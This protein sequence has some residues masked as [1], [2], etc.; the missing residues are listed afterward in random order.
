MPLVA[1]TDS[2]WWAYLFLTLL[3]V[4]M[5]SL[6]GAV[7]I[8]P[9]PLVL[10]QA[11]AGAALAWLVIFSGAVLYAMYSGRL[12]IDTWQGV[13][14]IAADVSASS[15]WRPRPFVATWTNRGALGR[16]GAVVTFALAILMA[17]GAAVVVTSLV[18]ALWRAISSTDPSSTGCRGVRCS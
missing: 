14:L 8:D 7:T 1:P 16:L 18:R 17:A 12:G 11:L 15:R 3:A 5:L 4:A 6:A 2:P 10:R 13:A 9:R